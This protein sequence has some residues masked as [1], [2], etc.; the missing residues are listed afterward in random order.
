MVKIRSPIST[1][2]HHRLQSPSSKQRTGL[3]M[4]F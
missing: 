3:T 2:Y 4:N 1:V